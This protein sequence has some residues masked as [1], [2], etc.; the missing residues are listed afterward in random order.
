MIPLYL[1]TPEF[2]EPSA[3]L[4]YLVTA[5]G[6][7]LV[8]K[9]ALFASVTEAHTVPGLLPQEASC[10]LF[11]PRVPRVMMEQVYGFF[12]AVYEHWHGEAIVFLYYA[13]E[14]GTFRLGVPPQTLF[15]YRLFDRWRTER[16]VVYG[17]L[18]RPQGFVKLGDVHSHADFPASFSCTDDR[19]D[20][21]TGL[22]II[23]GNLHQG[24]PE[25]SVSFVANGTRFLLE[26]EAAVEQFSLP[27]PPPQAWLEQVACQE[28]EEEGAEA[29]GQDP[30]PW[31][32]DEGQD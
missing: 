32:E 27:L 19:D 15:R 10:Q 17:S 20:T 12:Q 8:Q 11:F 24:Q 5:N 30:Y 16:R 28:E 1:K 31:G 25:V 23:L 18:P 2:V 29:T 21:E 26:P 14:S 6:T 3:S 9:T 4:Y 22:R 13:P 7:F